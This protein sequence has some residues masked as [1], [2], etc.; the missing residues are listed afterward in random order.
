MAGWVKGFLKGTVEEVAEAVGE[1][2][3]QLL[4]CALFVGLVALV[5]RGWSVSPV[6]TGAGGGL[7]ALFTGYGAWEA[8]R[9]SARHRRGRLASA[10]VVTAGVV[11][12]FAYFA[13]GC[14]C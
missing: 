8:F 3:L 14:S 6:L 5:V 7:F 2:L 4:A 12:V 11:A 1:L 10:A 13:S 9:G